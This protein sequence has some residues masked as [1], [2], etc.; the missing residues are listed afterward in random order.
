MPKLV[1]S[2]VAALMQCLVV[3]HHCQPVQTV[4]SFW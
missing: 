2:I 3:F 4:L 1:T